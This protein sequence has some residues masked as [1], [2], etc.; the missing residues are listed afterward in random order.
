MFPCYSQFADQN[1][2]DSGQVKNMVIT[3]LMNLQTNLFSVS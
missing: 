2:M 1:A 3:H